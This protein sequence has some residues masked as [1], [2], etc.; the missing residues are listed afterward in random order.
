[1]GLGPVLE[2][3]SR[4]RN[5]QVACEATDA[6]L[7]MAS[8]DTD[9][10]VALQERHAESDVSVQDKTAELTRIK[11][12]LVQITTERVELSMKLDVVAAESDMSL[13]Q[14]A[15]VRGTR[16]RFERLVPSIL[17]QL[18]ETQMRSSTKLG[19]NWWT[20]FEQC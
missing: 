15:V 2:I 5:P 17:V 13:E 10:V 8:R 7:E 11:T 18:V 4:D 20:F 9:E 16:D 14:L 1:M 19:I 6:N 3:K 12:Q